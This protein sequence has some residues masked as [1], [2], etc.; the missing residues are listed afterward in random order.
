MDLTCH[1]ERPRYVS[2]SWEKSSYYI[3][4]YKE[5]SQDGGGETILEQDGMKKNACVLAGPRVPRDTNMDFQRDQLPV[6]CG[7]AKGILYKEKMKKG[8]L[9]NILHF[10]VRKLPCEWCIVQVV[11]PCWGEGHVSK[12]VP[13]SGG[14]LGRLKGLSILLNSWLLFI[15]LKRHTKKISKGKKHMV[16]MSVSKVLSQRGHR[17]ALNSPAMMCSVV[18]EG[19][20]P[21][22]ESPGLLPGVSYVSTLWLAHAKIPN[23]WKESRHS[24]HTISF[25]PTVQ[26]QW[27][28]LKPG[29][30][31]TPF[32]RPCSQ[33]PAKGHLGT[34]LSEESRLNSSLL[35]LFHIAS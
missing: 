14:S 30:S 13:R 19:S 27:A 23:S 2:N 10:S 25:I 29:N 3:L 33:M 28:T 24:T 6:T 22:P 16:Q 7:E 15:L 4:S 11:D 8:G 18:C 35:A 21:E 31:E 5:G 34:R 1:K 12:T 32:P 20:C 17:D 9:H 26:A